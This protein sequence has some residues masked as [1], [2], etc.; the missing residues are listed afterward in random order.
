[1]YDRNYATDEM[2]KRDAYAQENQL[3]LGAIAGSTLAREVPMAETMNRLMQ[4]ISSLDDAVNDLDQRT[5][6]LRQPGPMPSPKE[7]RTERSYSSLV[8]SI[9]DQVTKLERL[10][11][12]IRQ[13]TSE[14][15]I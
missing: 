3:R 11:I 2:A 8:G 5:H 10:H 12:S 13:I 9:N 14:L 6:V 1:M 4:V 15:E 7:A